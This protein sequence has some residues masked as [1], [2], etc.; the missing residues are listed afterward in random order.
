MK[1][2]KLRSWLWILLI[3]FTIAGWVYDPMFGYVALI[4]MLSPVLFAVYKGRL[5]CGWF[6]PRGS[7]FDHLLGKFSLQKKIPKIMFNP[8]FRGAIFTLLMTGLGLQL[9]L[10]GG[11]LRKIGL[12]ILRL[13]TVTTVAGIV[14]GVFIH[15]RSWCTVC[16]MG[17]LSTL[18]G[19]GKYQ[20]E[21][22]SSCI[23]C[24]KCVKACPVQIAPVAF[25]PKGEGTETVT[26]PNC[27]KCERCVDI[28]PKK[29]LSFPKAG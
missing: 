12:V 7:F 6:C 17:S 21:I 15:P 22:K 24:K 2:H 3:A 28:C 8:Y 19:R 10:T 23:G 13:I 14:M 29:A 20:L 27:L 9:W 25:R 26:D 16:P 11:D 4:C 1:N 18:F 5:W